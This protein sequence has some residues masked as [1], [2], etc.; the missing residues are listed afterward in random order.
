M[1]PFERPFFYGEPR[2]SPELWVDS[3]YKIVS[4]YTSQLCP[5]AEEVARHVESK[6]RLEDDGWSF[7]SLTEQDVPL[8]QIH[9]MTVSSFASAFAYTSLD[10]NDF[11]AMYGPILERA[12]S[13][14]I[15][16]ARSPEKLVSGY[17]F[18]IPDIDNPSLKQFIVKTL[19]V[20]PEARKIGVGGVLVGD[21][22]R[23][24]DSKGWTNGGIHALM[25]EGSNSQKIS[26]HKGQKF[27]EYALFSK[28]L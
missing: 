8:K 14:L 3:D 19:A 18:S 13:D 1:G 27:R 23:V 9:Q 10:L 16:F 4:R 22:H 28:N 2:F 25:W 26:A 12:D 11:L 20:L 5:N 15:R 17:C 21:A 7:F 6:S 24:A